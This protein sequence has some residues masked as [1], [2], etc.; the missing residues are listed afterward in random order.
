MSAPVLSAVQV[1][2]R[3]IEQAHAGY[4]VWVSDEGWWYATK[5]EPSA[6][7]WAATLDGPGPV[8]LTLALSHAEEIAWIPPQH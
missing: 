7:G 8:E 6:R 1:V 4:H 3:E 2:C 5:V